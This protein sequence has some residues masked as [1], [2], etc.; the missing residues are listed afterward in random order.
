MLPL[1]APATREPRP[2]ERSVA[3]RPGIVFAILG[4]F[5]IRRRRAWAERGGGWSRAFNNPKNVGMPLL[6]HP[7]PPDRLWN[8]PEI[9]YFVA[10]KLSKLFELPPPAIWFVAPSRRASALSAR[11]TSRRMVHARTRCSAQVLLVFERVSESKLRVTG[12]AE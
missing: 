5:S 10:E 4:R 1:P 8:S 6:R 3:R 7:P 2:V 12:Q 9:V 11:G